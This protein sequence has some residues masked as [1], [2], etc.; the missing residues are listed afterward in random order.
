[1]ATSKDLQLALTTTLTAGPS[2]TPDTFDQLLYSSSL[3]YL[4][5]PV[6]RS[7][8]TRSA[9]YPSEF[10]DSFLAQ[11]S[12]SDPLPPIGP[13][14]CPEGYTI[15][16]IDYGAQEDIP[17]GYIACCPSGYELAGPTPP[18]PSDRPAYGATC[19]SRA[20]SLLITP[21]ST[22]AALPAA[23]WIGTLGDHVYALPLEGYTTAVTAVRSTLSVDSNN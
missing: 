20:Q 6:P 13:L 22:E 3:I 14:V 5:Y 17:D 8:L 21:Y 23:T 9:C 15:A 16:N 7:G 2:C 19:R 10:I 4:N 18:W 12:T 1:M 11:Q